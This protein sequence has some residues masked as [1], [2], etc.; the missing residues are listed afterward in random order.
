MMAR[1]TSLALARKY[2]NF[3]LFDL[4]L[5]GGEMWR[6]WGQGPWLWEAEGGPGGGE[7]EGEGEDRRE[8]EGREVRKEQ[9][10]FQ[11]LLSNTHTHTLFKAIA[12]VLF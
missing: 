1:D 6:D 8:R 3:T 7:G 12:A 9:G 2:A 4:H 11:R 10:W 5:V